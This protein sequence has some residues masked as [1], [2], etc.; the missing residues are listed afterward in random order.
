M[1]WDITML[2]LPLAVLAQ[3]QALST[4]VEAGSSKAGGLCHSCRQLASSAFIQENKDTI[5]PLQR[6]SETDSTEDGPPRLWDRARSRRVGMDAQWVEM[7]PS[8]DRLQESSINCQFCY[9]LMSSL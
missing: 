3:L 7:Q 2:V 5:Q 4:K 6:L 8:L 9:L 1:L